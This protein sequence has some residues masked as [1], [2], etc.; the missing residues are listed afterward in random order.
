[1]AV[2]VITGT[3]SGIGFLTAEMLARAGHAVYATMRERNGRN[4]EAAD[5]L[6]RLGSE[7]RTC[8]RNAPAC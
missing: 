1:M 4:R 3:S 7:H 6:L 8:G 2:V 5:A